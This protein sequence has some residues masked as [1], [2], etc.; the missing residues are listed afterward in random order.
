MRIS[1]I[2][3]AITKRIT[4]FLNRASKPKSIKKIE[5]RLSHITEAINN[6][7]NK[8]SI[9]TKDQ[10]EYAYRGWKHTTTNNDTVMFL[11]KEQYSIHKCLSA[12]NNVEMAEQMKLWR[13]EA[14]KSK[15]VIRGCNNKQRTLEDGMTWYFLVVQPEGL[16]DV[17]M[18]SLGLMLLGEMVSGFVYAFTRKANRDMVYE[19][20]MRGIDEEKIV[21]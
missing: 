9:I 16:E 14:K 4:C 20:V 1:H 15:L 3:E 17:G 11:H 2:T 12:M 8:M 13:K 18:D 7:N 6:N 10:I 21:D 19:Y 5:L